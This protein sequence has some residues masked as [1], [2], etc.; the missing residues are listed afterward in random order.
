MERAM[1]PNQKQGCIGNWEPETANER[2]PTNRV[3]WS[4]CQEQLQITLLA[5]DQCKSMQTKPC[6]V[7]RIIKK[8]V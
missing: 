4:D 2:Q 7:V 6:F 8:T 5:G 3:L 1:R